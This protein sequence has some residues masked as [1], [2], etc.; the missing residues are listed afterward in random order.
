M[1]LE[2]APWIK[3]YLVDMDNLYT[4]LILEKLENMPY[5]QVGRK[6]ENYKVM[7]AS[8]KPGM[9]EYLD[10][11]YYYPNL[12]PKVKILAKGDPGIGKTSL[13]KKIA[14][15]WA[16]G[17][18]TK[19]SIVFFV[20][21][22]LVKPEDTIENAIIMQTPELEGM[23]VTKELL[24]GILEKFGNQCLLILDGLDEHALGQNEDVHKIIRGAKCLNCNVILTSRPHSTG[25][26]ERYFDTIVRVEG[27]TRDE[28]RK[29]ASRIVH[30]EKKVEAILDFKPVGVENLE[31]LHSIPI[32]LS[33]L[34]LLVRENDIDLPVKAMDPGELYIKMMH[35]L[36]KKYTIRKGIYFE[37]SSF[38][39][40]LKLIGKIAFETLLSENPFYQRS[41]ISGLVGD[42]AF[43]YGL[44]I[45]H[46]D[47]RLIG[48]ETADIMVTFPHRSL[49]E[50][51]GAF[52][53]V[54]LLN[55]GVSID[56]LL[57][58]HCKKPIFMTNPLFLQ[59]AIWIADN[60]ESMVSTTEIVDIKKILS[61]HAAKVAVG[62][63]LDMAD[64]K[65]EFPTVRDE[66]TDKFCFCILDLLPLC[67]SVEHLIL[68]N[69]YNTDR[70]MFAL[71][72]NFKQLKSIH[73]PRP[74]R[75]LNLNFVHTPG[76][77]SFSGLY[78]YDQS[79]FNIFLQD[80]TDKMD[81]EV[82]NVVL[83]HCKDSRHYPCVSCYLVSPSKLDLKFGT[84]IS[85]RLEFASFF[86]KEMKGFRLNGAYNTLSCNKELPD[87]PL[88]DQL[89]LRHVA[90]ENIYI[91]L[92]KAI[93]EKRFPLLRHL[94]FVECFFR[95]EGKLSLLFHSRCPTL[96]HLGLYDFRLDR[97]D[98]QFLAPVNNNPERSLL[99]ELSSLGL[100]SLSLNHST[101]V[102]STLF[103]QPWVN[104][105]GI[106]FADAN[107]ETFLAFIDVLNKGKLLNLTEL[108]MSARIG[109]DVDFDIL[110]PK[111]VSRLKSLT[112]ARIVTSAAK[113]EQLIQKIVE[114]E[115]Q[116]LNLS[117]NLGISGSLSLFVNHALP[118]LKSL[119]LR[120]C[121][122][123]ADDMVSL[124]QA[125]AE[126]KFPELEYLDVA[127]NMCTRTMYHLTRVSYPG[128]KVMWKSV[129]HD[130]SDDQ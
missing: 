27:F 106:T 12:S 54:L 11:K 119:I 129:C 67:H 92:S 74:R 105:T 112:L 82:F 77:D 19:V 30:D 38:R 34:C 45:G 93:R 65:S 49:Q 99:P 73:I 40:A 55:E 50:F 78:V 32:L 90:D 14:W 123:Q 61:A 75:S 57:G 122:L 95:M 76:D 111:Q 70:V 97:S 36:Y 101:S 15:D 47:F 51:L 10:I 44:L 121:R 8:H 16:K 86:S 130:V 6:L 43:D 66:P 21:L 96:K 98:L 88:L 104:L 24:S 52:Y 103:S 31:S 71:R 87:C 115:L 118:P 107:V 58:I 59:F 81:I 128:Q 48:D 17:I 2:P 33:I 125:N 100:S 117:Y 120:R 102:I 69:S 108:R 62:S 9:L 60:P 39:E 110:Q 18:F 83:K 126:G 114:W 41:D 42:D 113:L 1:K 28:A 35:C 26:I 4:E 13:V 5:G 22:K 3:D 29:F 124:A 46:E 94:T 20:F 63:N 85:E 37:I 56:T 68:S 127:N 80:I 7:F 53:F 116:D 89:S 25:G 109:E 84:F 79:D 72:R 23:R 64:F 91:A